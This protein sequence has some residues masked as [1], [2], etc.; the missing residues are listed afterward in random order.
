MGG[1]R[2]NNLAGLFVLPFY[3]N[4]VSPPLTPY[5]PKRENREV[6]L[7]ASCSSR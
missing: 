5:F 6:L 3:E 2:P 1:L 7:A 4:R